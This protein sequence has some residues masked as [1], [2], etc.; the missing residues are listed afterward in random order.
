MRISRSAWH[1]PIAGEDTRDGL[2]PCRLR[3]TAC[4]CWP[5]ASAT[6]PIAPA[7]AR[8]ELLHDAEEGLLGFDCIAPL[9]PYLGQP[10]AALCER[11]TAAVAE[12]YELPALTDLQRQ[13]HK[14]ADR[15]A[16][17]SEAV[18]ISSWTHDQVR[19]DLRFAERPLERDPLHDPLRD[20]AY[21][22]WEPWPAEHSASRWLDELQ[23][24]SA[25]SD[26]GSAT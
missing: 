17:A 19:F 26:P 2:D 12:R 20:G 11:L 14:A 18:Q 5:S 15:L 10:F 22:P 24:R 3:S 8:F 7:L 25:K 23:R 21:A 9:K 4:S 1:A 13:E 6:A 16:A